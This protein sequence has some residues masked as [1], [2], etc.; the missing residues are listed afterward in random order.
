MSA[1]VCWQPPE[2]PVAGGGVFPVR[3]VWCVGRN[4][5][6]HA[7]EMG[8]DPTRSDPVFFAKPASAVGGF[9]EVR[10]PPATEDLHHEVELVVLLAGGGRQ[11]PAADWPALI[12]GFAVGVDLT[13]RCAQARLKKGGQPWE[14]AKGFDQS[15]P[16]GMVVP[17]AQWQP[18]DDRQISLEVNGMVR[19]QASLGE[20]IWSV[21]ELLARLSEQVSLGAGDLIFTGTPA[22]VGGLHRGDRVLARIDGLPPLEFSIAAE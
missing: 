16:V 13:R 10:Y 4:Y 12:Y 21:S 22:G 14:M 11:I 18:Q 1:V 17:V 15:G 19:Q 7:R 9:R 6:E 2:L 3:Q 8:V 5:A 20:M